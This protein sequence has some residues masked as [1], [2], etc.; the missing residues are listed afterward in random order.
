M[1][2]E[3]EQASG[4]VVATNC[5]WW[6]PRP[7]RQ[8]KK[9]QRKPRPLRCG[10]QTSRGE[11][12]EREPGGRSAS[13]SFQRYGLSPVSLQVTKVDYRQFADCSLVSRLSGLSFGLGKATQQPF[14]AIVIGDWLVLRIGR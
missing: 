3:I 4:T 9:G 5:R 6:A 2:N 1:T 14:D 12:L 8:E 11:Q 13:I 7:A 10:G